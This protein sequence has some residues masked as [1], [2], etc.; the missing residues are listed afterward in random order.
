MKNLFKVAGLVMAG[1]L[2]NEYMHQ[3]ILDD[4]EVIHED[5]EKY[6]RVD[7]GKACGWSYGKV[8]WKKPQE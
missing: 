1:F 6:I 3:R 8:V 5:D 7:P 4:G 2:V